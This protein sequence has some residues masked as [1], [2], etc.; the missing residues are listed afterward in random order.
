MG[1]LLLPLLLLS[2]SASAGTEPHR[3]VH[4][5]E[6]ARFRAMQQRDEHG[7]IHPNGYLRALTQRRSLLRNPQ[8]GQQAPSSLLRPMAGISSSQQS[9]Q[10]P[11]S[12]LR[13][14]A[15]ISSSQWTAL[16]P[17][18]IGG[19]VRSLAIQPTNSNKLWAGSVSGG[20]WTSSDAGA[21][22]SPVNDFLPNLAISSIVIDPNNPNA[23]Y[24][25]T[26]EGFFNIDAIR[27]AGIFKSTDGGTTW[28]Q[29]PATNP[30]NPDWQY[31][32]RIA[33][34]PTNGDILL[35]GTNSGCFRSADGGATWT[36][37]DTAR[38]LDVKF[39]PNNGNN[40]ISGRD[41]GF[42]SYSTDAGVTWTSSI[43]SGAGRV[44]IAY[45]KNT[46]DLVYASVDVNNGS[47]YRSTDGGR[48]WVFRIIGHLDVSGWYA[49]AIW[50]DPTNGNQLVIGGLDLYRSSNAGASFTKISTWQSSPA[51]P[52]ADH[53][54]IVSDP[55]YNGSTNRRVYFGNDGGIYRANDITLVNETDSTNNGWTKLN[56]GLAITQFYSGA[57]GPGGRLIGGTQDNGS[58]LYTGGTNWLE[59][60][61][62]DGGYSA[63]DSA[64][65]NYLYGEYVYLSIHRSTVGGT[66]ANFICRGIA[67]G[68][69]T[70]C[71]GTG[72][73]N[74]IAPFI[75]DP[76]NNNRMLAGGASLWVS[77][78]VKAATPSWQSIKPPTATSGISLNISAIAVA[79]GNSDIIW[80]GHNNGQVYRTSNGTAA[81]P[82]WTLV[83][84]PGALP[85][86]FVTRIVTRILIDK[87]NTNKV[88]ITFG[89][90]TSGNVQRTLN[91]GATW[92]DISGSL[93]Q[94]PVRAITSHPSNAN[95][96]YAG[97]EVGIFTSED[98]GNSWFTTND[99]PASVSVDELFWLDNST[100]VAA[101]H[102]RGMFKITAA[103]AT[104]PV[105]T[106]LEMPWFTKA[107]GYIS[108]F[109]LMNTGPSAATF[110]VT[111]LTESGNTA[112]INPLFSSGSILAN[113]QYIINVS[114]L[115]LSFSAGQRAGAI[116]TS[117]APSG[118]LLGSYNL[119][120]P[121][122]GA[123]SNV[124][125]LRGQDFASTSS[126]LQAPWFSLQSG[127]SSVFVLTNAGNSDALAQV[128][129]LAPSGSTITPKISSLTIPAQKQLIVDAGDLASV[130]GG[131]QG[132]AVFNINAPEGNIKGTY[133]IVDVATGT[134]SI[135]EFVNPQSSSG[136][137][138]RLV[139]PWFS[140]AVSYTSKFFLTNK[141]SSAASYTI[142]V[143]TETGNSA[144][145]GTLSGSIPAHSQVILPATSIVTSFFGATRAS[146]IF[147]VSAQ[148]ADIEGVY[149][150]VS[151]STGAISNTILARPDSSSN[152]STTLKLP[153]FSG[154]PGYI[155]RF[156]LINRGTNPA[157]FSIQI[158]PETGNVVT[159]SLTSG[160][161][162]ANG[163]LVLPVNSVVSGFTSATRAAAIFNVSAP[164]A[165]IDG[166]YNIVEPISGTISNT[167]M[168]H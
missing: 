141:G 10:A 122:T 64:D 49:N 54:V 14:M 158:L 115:I 136:S 52:H 28:T 154:A 95:F 163:Q 140:T 101:T 133:K 1:V 147:D 73:A 131:T 161:I 162:P 143:L 110:N 155:S 38:T 68:D 166:Q 17:G 142:T 87:S 3:S 69:S 88:Y 56:N 4:H 8:Q 2:A 40:A 124:S 128:S 129:F 59:Y 107:S 112:T 23:M 30:N 99:G 132:A 66:P 15:G 29:L 24:A 168:Q 65:S 27:G 109:V 22:W 116:I 72:Q 120:Q 123:V 20:I 34:H 48:T 114:D 96:L 89:G 159:Q 36:K 144:T 146:A 16:G 25:G 77:N 81:T 33:I 60:F 156:V 83:S 103:S 43:L 45:A 126:V 130:T 106:V 70:E 117:N 104:T 118:T 53:H 82:T 94:A 113:S 9:Q 152:P 105:S 37:V 90:Y 86:R 31:V 18:N 108:R 67:D 62:G 39:D 51:S 135:T 127:Y 84:G 35:A 13:P 91:N 160:T 55:G 165:D 98:G 138:T 5:A 71:G 19:R 121:T 134:G 26:G 164:A 92:S 63:V 32:N 76:N 157:P 79:A 75:L 58:L 97:S 46:A 111:V 137:T 44:E 7:V 74:F 41:D 21:S 93:P 47:V 57:S 100:L 148:P 167:L 42:V 139:A 6:A 102:G 125:L 145:T 149:Q 50:V 151:Q 119:V 61:S 150:I 12:S 85:A 153:W 80:V 11:G 78:N